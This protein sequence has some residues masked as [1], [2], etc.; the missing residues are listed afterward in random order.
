VRFSHGLGH[1]ADDDHEEHDHDRDHHGQHR[2]T[3]LEIGHGAVEE[4][5]PTRDKSRRAPDTE[6]AVALDLELGQIEDHGQH[7]ESDAH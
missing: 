1:G 7:D 3:D 5:E 6:D 2:P 4:K